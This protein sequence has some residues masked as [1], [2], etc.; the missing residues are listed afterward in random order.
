[1]LLLSYN[2]VT[3]T[4]KTQPSSIELEVEEPGGGGGAPS[5]QILR[6]VTWLGP[7]FAKNKRFYT[8]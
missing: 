8:R 4:K 6:Q 1:M 7:L 3:K 2:K 5:A